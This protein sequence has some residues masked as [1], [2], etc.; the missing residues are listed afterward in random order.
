MQ[1]QGF[2]KNMP[3]WMAA[4]DCVITKAGPGTIAEALIRGLPIVLNDFIAGQV[5]PCHFMCTRFFDASSVFTASCTRHGLQVIFKLV[6]RFQPQTFP[7]IRGTRGTGAKQTT[8]PTR[9]QNHTDNATKAGRDQFT[10]VTC[11]TFQLSRV[12]HEGPLRSLTALSGTNLCHQ[13]HG[14]C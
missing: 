10:A 1:V 14:P 12:L 5:R 9:N 13:L 3:E 11:M 7:D 2:V 4:S 8:V 6:N